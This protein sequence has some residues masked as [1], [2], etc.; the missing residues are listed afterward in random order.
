MKTIIQ[1]G[2]WA[3]ELN[4]IELGIGSADCIQTFGGECFLF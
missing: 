4:G 3:D 2:F 1:A